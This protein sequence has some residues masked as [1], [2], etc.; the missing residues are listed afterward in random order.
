M[1]L[2]LLRPR[3]PPPTNLTSCGVVLR[4]YWGLHPIDGAVSCW[5]AL[6]EASLDHGCMKVIRGSHDK[7]QKTHSL[8]PDEP[9]SMLRR[10]Q[11]VMNVDEGKAE[12]M[13]LTRN[14]CLTLNH[15]PL[16]N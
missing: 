12:A 2:P 9:G 7:G 4:S 11:Q 13:A 14:H 8:A 15:C 3:P 1:A 5:V 10:G 6:T 16:F